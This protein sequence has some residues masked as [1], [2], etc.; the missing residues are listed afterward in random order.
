MLFFL[1]I[2][3]VIWYRVVREYE[4]ISYLPIAIG[5]TPTVFYE[6]QTLENH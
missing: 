1:I 6:L 5:I 4:A 3:N 2:A